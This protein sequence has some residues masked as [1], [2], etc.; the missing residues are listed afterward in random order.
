MINLLRVILIS[1]SVLATGCESIDRWRTAGTRTLVSFIPRSVDKQLGEIAEKGQNPFPTGDS[2]PPEAHEEIASLAQPL[3]SRANLSPLELKIRVT[4][5]NVP[6]A[7]AFPH[8]GIFV[9]TKLLQIS[10]QPEEI[11][12]VLAHEIA[13]VV[14]RHSMQNLVT[15]V[16]TSLAVSMVFGDMGTLADIA[17]TGGQLL[18]LKFS[19]DHERDA[20]ALGAEL[21]REAKLPLSGMQAFFERM[22]E[23]EKSSDGLAMDSG[24][25][26]IL[27]THPQTQE[28]IDTARALVSPQGAEVPAR[29]REAYARLKKMF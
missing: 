9:T 7:Y 26:S 15:Q 20:D 29:Q 12:A 10:K 3:L 11:L 27:K 19:R 18:N 8:G 4:R 17:S 25:L 22:N 13:H 21:L 1:A 2:L 28:R 5:A 23:F 6:N 16:G 14:Q 24:L